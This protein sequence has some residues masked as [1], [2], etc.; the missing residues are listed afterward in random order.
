LAE[1]AADLRTGLGK[2][3]ERLE[4]AVV[5]FFR[6]SNIAKT[7]IV[8]G[9]FLIVVIIFLGWLERT[10]ETIKT[11]PPEISAPESEQMK[12]C[13][14][15]QTAAHDEG[16][17]L[18]HEIQSAYTTIDNDQKALT[19][20]T[21]LRV[22]AIEKDRDRGLSPN[23]DAVNARIQQLSN[24]INWRDKIISSRR[25]RIG[26]VSQW[27]YSQCAAILARR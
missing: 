3:I 18:E 13:G 1:G 16:Q 23:E 26:N 24:D 2:L 25:E 7:L 4:D 12:A 11:W 20:E 17:T 22:E 5:E 8:C 14:T 10:G 19:E 15:I 27:V 6:T 9:T 21:R